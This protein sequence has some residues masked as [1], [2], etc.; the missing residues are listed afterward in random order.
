MID[1]PANLNPEDDR[2]ILA[3][4]LYGEARS[5]GKIGMRAVANTVLNRAMIADHY[6]DLHREPHPLYG[7]GSVASA[8]LVPWQYSCWNQNDPNRE[9]IEKVTTD[10]LAFND[11]LSIANAVITGV[12]DDITSGSTHYF[13][14]RLPKPPAW[15]KGKTPCFEYLHHVFFNNID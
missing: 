15:A 7:D 9:I 6:M 11:A 5:E 8:C 14:K 2:D 3:R 4:T 1:L 10:D 12:L 13:D